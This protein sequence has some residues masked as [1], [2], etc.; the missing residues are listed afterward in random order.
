MS[1][2]RRRLDR[3][4]GQL[5]QRGQQATDAAVLAGQAALL[6]RLEEYGRWFDAGLDDAHAPSHITPEQLPERR[7]MARRVLAVYDEFPARVAGDTYFG[8][9]EEIDP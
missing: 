6:E 7:A 2:N 9:E 5:R 3:L 4:E 8:T 1:L